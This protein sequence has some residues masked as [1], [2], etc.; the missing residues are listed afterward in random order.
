MA[1]FHDAIT[2]WK[3]ELCLMNSDGQMAFDR[4]PSAAFDRTRFTKEV[5]NQEKS[6]PTE[7]STAAMAAATKAVDLTGQQATP[8]VYT[9]E[10]LEEALTKAVTP[11]LVKFGKIEKENR[12]LREEYEA[13][14]ASPDPN[15]SAYRGATG[16]PVTKVTSADATKAARKAKRQAKKAD[17]IA[18]ARDLALSPDAAMRIHAQ[19]RLA[20]FGLD[21]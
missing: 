9:S 15:R 11:L 5:P 4:Q 13:L 12:T 2:S 17:E 1:A 7:V 6:T 10:E 3:P 8:K 20:R 14:A 19:K 21:A 18:L 16:M